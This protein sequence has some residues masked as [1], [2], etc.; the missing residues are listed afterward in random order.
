M[1]VLDRI[2]KAKHS[3]ELAKEKYSKGEKRLTLGDLDY[4]QEYLTA[5]KYLLLAEI[6][7]EKVWKDRQLLFVDD[8]YNKTV[9]FIGEDLNRLKSN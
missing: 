4:V 6:N 5:S 9:K 7:E 1:N 3:L 2:E 8:R